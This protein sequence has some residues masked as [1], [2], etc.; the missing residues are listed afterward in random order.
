M[1]TVL[2]GSIWLSLFRQLPN[3]LL[4]C[5]VVQSLLDEVKMTGSALH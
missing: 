3:A 2:P 5:P 1:T 4:C